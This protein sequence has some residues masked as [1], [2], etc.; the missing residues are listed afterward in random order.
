MAD[1]E[2]TFGTERART[3]L[4]LPPFARWDG[5]VGYLLGQLTGAGGVAAIWW[6]V[7]R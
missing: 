5:W 4:G 3:T 2:K 1:E 6:I 7:N